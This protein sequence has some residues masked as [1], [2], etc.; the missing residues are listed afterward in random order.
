[1]L[2]DSGWLRTIMVP[3]QN[4][5]YTQQDACIIRHQTGPLLAVHEVKPKATGQ[6]PTFEERIG[7]IIECLLVCSLNID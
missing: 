7:H 2:E 6:I 3:F 1:V 5:D 4:A